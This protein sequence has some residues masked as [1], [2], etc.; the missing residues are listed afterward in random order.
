MAQVRKLEDRWQLATVWSVEH[1]TPYVRA[2]ETESDSAACEETF[3]W[4]A[5][6]ML[7]EQ[8]LGTTLDHLENLDSLFLGKKCA[9]TLSDGLIAYR[10]LELP[11]CAPTEVR[12]LLQS[13][14][15]LESEC[16]F[17]DLLTDYWELP[18]NRPR[19]TTNS[20]GA[21]SIDRSTAILLANDLLNAGFECRVLDAMPCAMARATSMVMDDPNATSLAIEL[22]YQQTTITLVH[23]GQPILSRASRSIG[24]LSFL[25]RVAQSFEINIADAQTLLFQTSTGRMKLPNAEDDFANPLQQK[26]SGFLQGIAHEIDRTLHYV[27]RVHRTMVPTQI[28]LMGEGTRIPSIAS[29]VEEHVGL[30]TSTWSL[31]ISESL[32][33][34]QQIATYAV[35]SALSSLAWEEV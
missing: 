16:D 13:E 6:S 1:A 5:P 28:V 18:S 29:A 15:T 4:L 12:S 3:G 11:V 27:Q 20:F 9:A 30:S 32:F 25:E 23:D 17:E 33:G 10:E 34:N 26:L 8:G 31:N 7:R 19:S 35:A 2:T 14:I 21:V 24:L 22:G